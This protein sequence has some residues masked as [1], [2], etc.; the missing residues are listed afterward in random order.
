[1]LV[2]VHGAVDERLLLHRLRQLLRAFH[3]V[4][5]HVA[6][7]AVTCKLAFLSSSSITETMEALTSSMFAFVL[8]LFSVSSCPDLAATTAS[9]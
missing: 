1:M 7:A 5:Q 9:M 4:A 8:S 6:S 2:R 3:T